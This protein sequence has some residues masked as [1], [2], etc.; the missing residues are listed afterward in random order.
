MELVRFLL[1]HKCRNTFFFFLICLEKQG[2]AVFK[3]LLEYIFFEWSLTKQ[4]KQYSEKCFDTSTEYL[5]KVGIISHK[6]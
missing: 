5:L 2:C 6:S 3:Y 4:R 1:T